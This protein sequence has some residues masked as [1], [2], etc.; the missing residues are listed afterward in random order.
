[1]SVNDAGSDD[2]NLSYTNETEHRVRRCR[3]IDTSRRIDGDND[4]AL[5]KCKR[6]EEEPREQ[7]DKSCTMAF[8]RGQLMT[9][10][11]HYQRF[12][13]EGKKG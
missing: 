5:C 11:D 3:G 2:D 12:Q 13:H 4:A 6:R 1:M 10:E 8:H 9:R 7:K